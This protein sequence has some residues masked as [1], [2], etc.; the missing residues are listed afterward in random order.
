M[1][2]NLLIFKASILRSLDLKAL[3]TIKVLCIMGSRRDIYSL[4]N[5][6]NTK[7]K[8]IIYHNIEIT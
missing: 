3:I 5:S 2:L 4:L 8:A 6:Y 1:F 7:G